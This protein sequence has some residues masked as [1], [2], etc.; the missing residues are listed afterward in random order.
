MIVIDPY[1]CLG[2]EKGCADE[3]I[4][5]EAYKRKSIILDPKNTNNLT[6]FEFF[7]LNKSYLQ[8]KTNLKQSQSQDKYLGPTQN[9]LLPQMTKDS[10]FN[11][12]GNFIPIRQSPLSQ[13][14]IAQH[15]TFIPTQTPIKQNT[16]PLQRNFTAPPP[17]GQHKMFSELSMNKFD[18]IK[19]EQEMLQ[20]RPSS[21]NYKDLVKDC[22][23]DKLDNVLN[24]DSWN[25][26]DSYMQSA[27][28]LQD[29]QSKDA[30]M[31]IQSDIMHEQVYSLPKEYQESRNVIGGSGPVTSRDIQSFKS[32][33]ESSTNNINT[34]QLNKYEFKQEMYNMGK[35]YVSEQE[36]EA[37]EKQ[38]LL[39]HLLR[40]Q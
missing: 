6:K 16:G 1:D 36:K 23:N 14:T 34:R 18:P 33:Y 29:T 7:N 5:K 39:K 12:N 4:I 13:S 26:M 27:P 28:V 9:R 24:L 35:N 17:P 30:N 8:I 11:G 22:E 21:L 2:I 15:N 40:N 10:K 38:E 19:S 37:R 31:Y 32:V 3:N 25:G 20:Y